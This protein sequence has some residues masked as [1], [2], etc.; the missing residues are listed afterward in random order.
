MKHFC[1]TSRG[2][3]TTVVVSWIVR[4]V[5]L[6]VII[7]RAIPYR[8]KQI[9]IQLLWHIFEF[10]WLINIFLSSEERERENWYYLVTRVH[11]FH[12]IP[13]F[14]LKMYLANNGK[15]SPVQL[16]QLSPTYG[17]NLVF[18]TPLSIGCNSSDWDTKVPCTPIVAKLRCSIVSCK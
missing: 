11:L 7:D 18:L 6:P 17:N 12:K 13:R 2:K 1:W 3:R 14:H 8:Q 9:V 10:H 4:Y 15:P 16:H 5:L